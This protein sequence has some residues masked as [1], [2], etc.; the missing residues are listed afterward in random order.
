MPTLGDA[1]G[2]DGWRVARQATRPEQGASWPV[3]P[4]AGYQVGRVLGR[5]ITV[6]T[7]LVL[8]LQ[9]T[10]VVLLRGPSTRARA[11]GGARR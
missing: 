4:N 10:A 11:L 7:P 1:P 2:P 5:V 6:G 3:P 9:V 8:A